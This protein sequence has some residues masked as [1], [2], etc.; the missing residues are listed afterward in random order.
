MRRFTPI[1]AV[2]LLASLLANAMLAVR[3]SRRGDV[4]SAAARK[5]PSAPD[6]AVRPEE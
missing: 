2:L 5:A 4:E 1:L 6:R 3:L